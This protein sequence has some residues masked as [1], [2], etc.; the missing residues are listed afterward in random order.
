MGCLRLAG[1]VRSGMTEIGDSPT[2]WI[3]RH[4]RSYVG[5]GD[6]VG[7][8]YRNYEAAVRLC[9]GIEIHRSWCGRPVAAHNARQILESGPELA[10]G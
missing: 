3:V 10:I 7:H 9:R 6:S 2:G 1:V 4:I 8:H 5:S